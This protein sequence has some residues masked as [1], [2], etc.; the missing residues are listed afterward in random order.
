[1]HLL[2]QL[3][4]RQKNWLIASVSGF[5]ILATFYLAFELTVSAVYNERRMTIKTMTESA[6]SLI[7]N[8]Y[9]RYQAGQLTEAEAKAEAKEAIRPIRYGSKGYFFIYQS[10]GFTLLQPIKPELEGTSMISV[11]DPNGVP[12]IQEL[13]DVS[14]NGK[15]GFVSYQWPKTQGGELGNKTSY[16]IGFAPWDWFIGTGTYDEDIYDT[17]VATIQRSKGL[18]ALSVTFFVA[19][20]VLLTMINR[21]TLRQILRIKSHL[22]AFERGDF[23]KR[24]HSEGKDEFAQMLNSMSAV[25]SSMC[26]TLGELS[27]TASSVRSG[28]DDIASNNQNLAGRTKEQAENISRSNQNLLQAARSVNENNMR[29]KEASDAA[30]NSQQ[31][32]SKGE[33]VVQQAIT[34]MNAITASSEQVTDIV[35]V[36]DGIAFQTNLLAL[37]A[38]VEAARAGEQGRGFAVVATEVRSLASRSAASASEIKALIEQSVNNVQ[39]GSK[40]VTDSGE[41]LQEILASSRQVSELITKISSSTSEQTASI[42]MSSQSMN[43]VDSFV[44]ENSNMVD[45]VTVSSENLREEA[46]SLLRLVERF[47]IGRAA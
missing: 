26:N 33:Q 14:R 12:L 24:I 45:H 15:A 29:L 44:Q 43:D 20:L 13:A 32:A 31:T 41:I 34:A 36:I 5:V 28:I 23:S 42:E 4:I 9:K 21:D 6:Y 2:Q 40:L 35:N 3:S 7:D 22:E 25:Q 11:K 17:V 46:Q 39:A 37:N 38:A 16:A 8:S 18:V 47:E 1:M 27:N 30:S 19:M 10:D